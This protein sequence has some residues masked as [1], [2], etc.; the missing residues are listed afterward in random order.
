MSKAAL[1]LALLSPLLA[2][3]TAVPA[4]TG[5][6]SQAQ[7][8]R[9][10]K[11]YAALCKNCHGS[12]LANGVALP[13]AGASFLENRGSRQPYWLWRNVQRMPPGGGLLPAGQALDVTA[14]ILQYNGHAPGDE[15]LKEGTPWMT[16]AT[17]VPPAGSK[18]RNLTPPAFIP[19][20][21]SATPRQGAGPSQAELNNAY[22]SKSDWLYH[23]HDYSG[24][25]F[26]QS[27]QITPAN[28][29]QLRVACLF[30]FG[31]QSNFQTGPIVYQGRMYLTGL[32]TTAAIDARNCELIWKH[33]W[34]PRA[35]EAW[36]FNRGVAIKD[37]YLVRGTVDGYLVA[38]NMESGSLIWARRV[39]DSSIGEAFTMPPVIFEDKII[40]GPAVSE[41][42]ISGWV[43]AFRLTDGTPLW[44]FNTVPK[45]G[46]PGS[47]TW[48]NPNN[49]VIGGGGTWTPYALD[50][51][52]GEVFVP[53]ANPIPDF[54]PHLRGG[55]N[56]YTNSV[57]ALSAR[58]GKLVWHRQTVHRDSHDWDLTQAG[59]LYQAN[60]G[61]R[62]VKVVVSA[63]K[64][65][66]LRPIDRETRKYLYETPV[67]TVENADIPVTT[68]GIHACPG[69]KGGVAWNGPAYNPLTRMLY[70]PAADECGVF[71]RAADEDL[72]KPGVTNIGGTFRRDAERKGWITAVDSVSGAVRWQYRSPEPVLA[73]VTTTSGGVVFGGEL[74]GHFLTLNAKTGKV[75]HRFQTGGP[76]GGG[77]VTY[78]VG[79][80]QHVA[81]TS[82]RPSAFWSLKHVGSPT[83]V[84]FTLP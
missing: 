82:G 80:K 5:G 24:A 51:E 40:A 64:D 35:K 78:E 30:Q 9:G 27:A 58:T 41:A 45:A 8:Q 12:D 38:L 17:I 57:V 43:G 59:P 73:A 29:A 81:V 16:T 2:Q 68:E 21:P 47:E 10:E 23:T 74:T 84:V 7:A 56:L 3:H 79:G 28:A 20:E 11:Q 18:G 49:L 14:Y 15:E 62:D 39:A 70:T 69:I 54:Q 72:G 32:R 67:T 50:Q 52:K 36:Q 42:G 60:V 31:E 26:V 48:K 6:F 46:E 44:R 34:V 61:G 4:R 71:T 75:V 63:G 83:V 19:G 37:G 25:R 13:L 53:V 76:I 65:G 1:C 55:D 33:E 66:M 22:S 77:I